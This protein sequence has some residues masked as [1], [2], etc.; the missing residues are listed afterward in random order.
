MFAYR[1]WT[2]GLQQE[3][4]AD[5]V[6]QVSAFTRCYMCGTAI[7][8][9]LGGTDARRRQSREAGCSFDDRAWQQRNSKRVPSQ[10]LLSNGQE[11][12]NGWY[13]R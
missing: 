4:V 1:R 9:V 2:V 13:H 11:R 3:I 12:F 10:M 5:G 8:D 6:E 7:G